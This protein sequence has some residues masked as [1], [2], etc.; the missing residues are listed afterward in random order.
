MKSLCF[1]CKKVGTV[2]F[3]PG[4]IASHETQILHYSSISEIDSQYEP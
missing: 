2:S 4:H 1:L 3:V